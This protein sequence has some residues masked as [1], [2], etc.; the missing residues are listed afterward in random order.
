M[1]SQDWDTVRELP[2]QQAVPIV[3]QEVHNA[4]SDYAARGG[5]QTTIS[6]NLLIDLLI[7]EPEGQ[8]PTKAKQWLI[9]RV[10][11]W[12]KVG[13]E[14]TFMC[15][16][17]LSTK[18]NRFSGAPQYERLWYVPPPPIPPSPAANTTKW[19][20]DAALREVFAGMAQR[21]TSLTEPERTFMKALDAFLFPPREDPS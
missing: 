18:P 19:S 1:S 16:R 12:S 14:L 21:Y 8:K 9:R 13:K 6:T 10:L 2:W 7:P 4:L 11:D 3:R 5:V 20:T 15:E 17:R